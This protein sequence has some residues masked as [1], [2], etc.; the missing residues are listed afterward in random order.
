MFRKHAITLILET[1]HFVSGFCRIYKINEEGCFLSSNNPSFLLFRN[2]FHHFSCG[3]QIHYS[4]FTKLLYLRQCRC[5]RNRKSKKYYLHLFLYNHHAITFLQ[6]YLQG[7]KKSGYDSGDAFIIVQR[8]KASFF[9]KT[10]FKISL[11]KTNN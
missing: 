7:T 6:K 8:D 3:L 1:P 9:W 11:W 5:N 2:N 4:S 10:T